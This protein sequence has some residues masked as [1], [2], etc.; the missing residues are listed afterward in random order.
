[1]IFLGLDDSTY[2]FTVLKIRSKVDGNGELSR[3]TR[4]GTP[5]NAKHNPYGLFFQRPGQGK[6]NLI[7]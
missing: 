4:L 6:G 2:L 7:P 1:M 3:D 5:T